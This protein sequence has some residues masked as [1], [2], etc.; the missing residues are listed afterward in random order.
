MGPQTSTPASVIALLPKLSDPD[1]DIRYMSLNDLY[2]ILRNG[3]PNFLISDY[4]TCNRAADGL[5]KTLDD[6]NGE[7]QNQAIKWSVS[8]D[9]AL[10][11]SLLILL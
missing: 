6:Q 5:L 10:L 7:V 2:K 11:M 1:S 8:I 9:I 4:P 3:A